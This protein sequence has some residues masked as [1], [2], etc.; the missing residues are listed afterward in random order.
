MA[1]PETLLVDPPKAQIVMIMSF[2][3]QKIDM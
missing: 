1:P 2:T 3:R